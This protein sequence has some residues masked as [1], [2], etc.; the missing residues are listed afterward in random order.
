[1]NNKDA[2]MVLVWWLC[3]PVTWA[4][5]YM[6]YRVL[7]TNPGKPPFIEDSHEH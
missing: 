2:L 4:G 1:M 5:A 7:F 3:N 6:L